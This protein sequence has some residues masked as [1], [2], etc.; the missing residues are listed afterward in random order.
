MIRLDGH[1]LPSSGLREKATRLVDEGR[2][3][4]SPNGSPSYAYRARV[5]SDHGWHDVYF[6]NQ[7]GMCSCLAGANGSVCS[8]LVA[9]MIAFYEQNEARV[10]ASRKEGYDDER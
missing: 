9:C 7:G 2:V 8:H 1:R 3:D 5:K 10:R 6:D 4:L